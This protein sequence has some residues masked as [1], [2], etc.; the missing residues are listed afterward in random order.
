MT[1]EYTCKSFDTY[2]DVLEYLN[3][4]DNNITKKDIISITYDSHYNRY[5]LFHVY[6]VY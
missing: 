1:M 3:N 4:P 2:L 5:R 6:Y